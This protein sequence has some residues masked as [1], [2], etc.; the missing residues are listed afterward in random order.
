MATPF[1]KGKKGTNRAGGH[2]SIGHV[3]PAGSTMP[4]TS[5]ALNRVG[6]MKKRMTGASGTKGMPK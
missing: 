2:T 4:S 3:T 1:T 6:S 5:A